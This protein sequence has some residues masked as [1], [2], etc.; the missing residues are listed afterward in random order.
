MRR[1]QLTLF[2]YAPD[3]MHPLIIWDRKRREA[4]EKKIIMAYIRDSMTFFG[5]DP[6][7]TDEEIEQGVISFHE[8]MRDFGATT[9]EAAS[10]ITMMTE[11]IRGAG[12]PKSELTGKDA[13]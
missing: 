4:L 11:T 7:L 6:N 9:A 2:F 1:I 3:W 10:G 13:S 12:K 8:V 5:M